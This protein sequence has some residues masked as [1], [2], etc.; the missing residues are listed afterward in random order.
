MPVLPFSDG[1][2][3]FEGEV[4]PQ[5]TGESNSPVSLFFAR[6]GG[7]GLRGRR[8][9]IPH[10]RGGRNGKGGSGMKPTRRSAAHRLLDDLWPKLGV[11]DLPRHV[12]SRDGMLRGTVTGRTWRCQVEG[13][14]G[15]RIE[16]RWPD[17]TTT[18]PCSK[19]MQVAGPDTWRIW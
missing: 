12:V 8:G 1:Q 4:T 11:G 5:R 3:G 6:I 7:P 13:C 17:G 16:V 14:R 2:S 18:R 15:T 19:G 10:P 9:C